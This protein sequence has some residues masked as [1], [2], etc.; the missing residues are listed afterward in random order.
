MTIYV[1]Q[2]QSTRTASYIYFL[3]QKTCKVLLNTENLFHLFKI[4]PKL[5]L[6]GLLS[7]SGL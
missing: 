6:K 7:F 4:Y 1:T 5:Y 2:G 3:Y